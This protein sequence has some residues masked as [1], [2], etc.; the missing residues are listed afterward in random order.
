M[1][2]FRGCFDGLA[3]FWVEAGSPSL[4]VMR[5]R[6]IDFTSAG[7]VSDSS[8]SSVVVPSHG[9]PLLVWFELAVVERAEVLLQPP[10]TLLGLPQLAITIHLS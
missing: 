9:Q 7:I 10:K 6:A 2:C 1:S 3:P 8:A 5:S 4:N